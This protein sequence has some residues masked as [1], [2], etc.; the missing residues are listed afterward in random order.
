MRVTNHFVLQ[1][2]V[3]VAALAAVG[4]SGADCDDGYGHALGNPESECV[5]CSIRDKMRCRTTGAYMSDDCPACIENEA[6]LNAGHTKTCQE[7]ND[8]CEIM[9][10]TWGGLGSVLE[11]TVSDEGQFE[12]CCTCYEAL[13]AP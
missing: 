2:C 13:H 8:I 4:V 9:K 3:I 12:A 5:L 6:L 10:Q 7:H 1:V 11:G